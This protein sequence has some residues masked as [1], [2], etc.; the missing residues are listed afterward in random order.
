ML[1]AIRKS[2]TRDSTT[3]KRYDWFNERWL[4]LPF[5]PP[6]PLD[7]HERCDKCGAL[8]FAGDW[9]WCSGNREDHER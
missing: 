1:G 6:I 5:S 4:K 3:A 9:P 8:L 2:M 7:N